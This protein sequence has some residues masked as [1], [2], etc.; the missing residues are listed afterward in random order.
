MINNVNNDIILDGVNYL[1]WS[2]IFLGVAS[3]SALNKD[4]LNLES[5]FR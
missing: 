5:S 1:W 4:L 3:A 2:S